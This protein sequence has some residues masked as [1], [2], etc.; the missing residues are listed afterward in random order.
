MFLRLTIG[1][2]LFSKPFQFIACHSLFAHMRKGC[3]AAEDISLDITFK[4]K[5]L[6]A[7]ASVTCALGFETSFPMSLAANIA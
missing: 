5:V 6:L 3:L 4:A 7:I 2:A 1:D